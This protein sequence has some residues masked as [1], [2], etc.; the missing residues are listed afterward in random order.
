MTD[1]RVSAELSP[2]DF[3]EVM[4]AL[5]LIRKKLSFLIDLSPEERRS[6]PRMGDKT[7]AFVTKAL[8]VAVQNEEILPRSFD[9]AEMKRDVALFESLYPLWQRTSQLCEL[10]DDTKLAVGS[11]AYI[12]AL[13]VYN[14]AKLNRI[15]AG[16]DSALDDLGKRF[17]R[18][19]SSPSE[20][21]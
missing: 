20:P 10:I 5:Q 6:L 14:Y 13:Q 15:D 18:R 19:V 17:A 11:E 1:N 8:E 21:Q 3:Q 4:D 16:L 9:L 7:R 12:A 2:A